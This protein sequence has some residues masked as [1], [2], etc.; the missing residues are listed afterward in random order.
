VS[1]AILF[2]GDLVRTDGALPVIDLNGVE[3]APIKT[4]PLGVARSAAGHVDVSNEGGI[5]SGD[6]DAPELPQ[7]T[8]Q[9]QRPVTLLI[10][11]LFVS[12]ATL[13]DI[14][15]QTFRDR[16]GDDFVYMIGGSFFLQT[17]IV[18]VVILVYRGGARARTF[19]LFLCAVSLLPNSFGGGGAVWRTAILA[20][21]V[22][23]LLAVVNASGAS[24]PLDVSLQS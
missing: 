9:E 23:A 13:L 4:L 8:L 15:I 3:A 18:W 1:S 14:V 12:A 20:C 19:L 7:E 21:Y 24:D 11:L 5:A 2:L 17:L 6:R 16:G 10:G 22:F